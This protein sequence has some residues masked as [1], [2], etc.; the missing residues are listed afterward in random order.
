[1]LRR[2]L[3]SALVMFVIAGFVLAG[4]YNGTVTKIDKD[5]VTILVKK[6]KKDKN[7]EEK[8]FKVKDLKVNLKSGKKG[9][10][11]KESTLDDITKAISESKGKVKGVNATIETDGEGDKEVVTK[12]NYSVGG[13]KKNQ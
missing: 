10:D 2:G 7:P 3:A 6:D 11:L 5:S 4:T 8:T 9:A 12:V 13:K 1:M